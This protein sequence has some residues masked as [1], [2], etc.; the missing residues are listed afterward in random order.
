V[1]SIGGRHYARHDAPIT[2]LE[3]VDAGFHVELPRQILESDRIPPERHRGS[4][5]GDRRIG[6]ARGYED[7]R[8]ARCGRFEDGS[9]TLD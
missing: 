7:G 6:G 1:I 3:V 8:T 9:A 4:E 2:I 5:L